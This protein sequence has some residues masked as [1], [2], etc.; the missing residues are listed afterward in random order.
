[1]EVTSKVCTK[2]S[3]EKIFSSFHKK[4]AGKYGLHSICKDCRSKQSVVWASENREQVKQYQREY[5]R[6]QLKTDEGRKRHAEINSKYYKS[7]KDKVNAYYRYKRKNDD[8]FALKC[9]VRGALARA[10]T[11]LGFSKCS[12]TQEILGCT[13]E[14]FKTHIEK[15]FLPGMSWAKR[16]Q[17]H[18][19]HIVALATA[20]TEADVIALNHFTNLRTLWGVDNIKKGAKQTHLL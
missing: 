3:V 12:K 19:D 4:P 10:I 2:C 14:E 18:I 13:W 17:I 5:K 7:N 1:M 11:R 20:K 16:D 8:L 6:R 9:S 15:Q